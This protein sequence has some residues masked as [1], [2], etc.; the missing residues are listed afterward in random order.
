MTVT[1]TPIYDVVA[2]LAL[3][4]G[5]VFANPNIAQ[6]VAPYA[7]IFFSGLVGVLWALSRQ[8]T[9]MTPG[10]RFR[11][12]LFM[13]R[14][15][16]AAMI[17]TIPLAVFLAPRMGLEQDRYAIAPIAFIIGAVGDDWKPLLIWI[18][19]FILRWKSGT[20]ET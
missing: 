5:V 17:A 15:I 7:A 8:E 18:R 3:L 16:G 1:P 4:G 2:L 20:P 11:G 9:D 14:I 12:M 13:G 10:H 19:D 6:A